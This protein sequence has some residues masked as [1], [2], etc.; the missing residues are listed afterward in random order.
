MFLILKVTPTFNWITKSTRELRMTIF[1]KKESD[2][3]WVNFFPKSQDQASIII[4]L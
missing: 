1:Q 2:D 4:P 3:I